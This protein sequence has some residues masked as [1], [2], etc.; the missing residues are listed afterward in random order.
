MKLLMMLSKVAEAE[1]S[2]S[3]SSKETIFLK[4]VITF[5][6]EKESK[7]SATMSLTIDITWDM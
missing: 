1:G 7:W 6:I 5:L 3:F 2:L 4:R